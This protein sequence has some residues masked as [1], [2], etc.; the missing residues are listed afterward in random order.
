MSVEVSRRPIGATENSPAFQ[1][2]V[3][4][5]EKLPSPEG[6]KEVLEMSGTTTTRSFFRPYGTRFLLPP[7]PT[8]ETVGYSRASLR[9]SE[10]VNA[11]SPDRGSTNR[12]A[13]SGMDALDYSQAS[14]AGGADAGHRPAL[15][16][17]GGAR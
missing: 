5:M 8:V 9:D 17:P 14:V 11:A 4:V 12:S 7:I 13:L 16:T 6:T 2:W 3:N 1:R 15:R 10:G